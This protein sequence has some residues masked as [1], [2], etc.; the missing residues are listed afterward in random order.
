MSTFN[1]RELV[2][3]G[4]VRISK[5]GDDRVMVYPAQG[6]WGNP[7]FEL[8]T[9]QIAALIA[10]LHPDPTRARP[11]RPPE[12]RWTEYIDPLIDIELERG[13]PNIAAYVH[14]T[15]E[16]YRRVWKGFPLPS[17]RTLQERVAMRRRMRGN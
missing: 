17:V 15:L 3:I 14:K 8:D 11:G 5:E 16:V 2:R 9:D 7:V 4:R 12:I 13:S 6:G 10:A 1:I